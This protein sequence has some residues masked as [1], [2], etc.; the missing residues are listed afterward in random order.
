MIRLTYWG[1]K[2]RLLLDTVAFIRAIRAPELLGSRAARAIENPDNVLEL[3][4][5]SLTEMVA[6]ARAV[7]LAAVAE[8]ILKNGEPKCGH[9]SAIRKGVTF[10]RNVTDWGM[11]R[12]QG[13]GTGK[14]FEQQVKKQR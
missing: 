11:E 12:R 7:S 10:F 9:R 2:L 5:I 8:S 1:S 14:R 13:G 3:S 6:R 4:T